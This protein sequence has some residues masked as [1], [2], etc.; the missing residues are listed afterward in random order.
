MVF[1]LTFNYNILLHLFCSARTQRE[2]TCEYL[3]LQRRALSSFLFT[4]LYLQLFHLSSL[5][6]IWLF[7]F[8]IHSIFSLF[9]PPTLTVIRAN[10]RKILWSW[11]VCSSTHHIPFSA[12]FLPSA[13]HCWVSK[14]YGYLSVPLL[15][16]FYKKDLL[17]TN[18]KEVMPSSREL[19]QGLKCPRV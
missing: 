19:L 5:P 13:H 3:L 15:P 4:S 10:L 11:Q 17:F 12:P 7:S 16:Y 18:G 1:Q 9:F 6:P 2:I 14:G 8:L